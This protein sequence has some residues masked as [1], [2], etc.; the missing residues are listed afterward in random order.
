MGSEIWLVGIEG[1]T[2]TGIK[3]NTC[4][5]LRANTSLIKT[6]N[7]GMDSGVQVKAELFGKT[8]MER[9][10]WFKYRTEKDG[11]CLQPSGNVA[12]LLQMP[13]DTVLTPL[14]GSYSLSSL[15]LKPQIWL[16]IIQWSLFGQVVVQ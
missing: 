12:G 13:R 7:T 6:G 15:Y 10:L 9:G 11:E 3:K 16:I 1:E 2:K 4:F 5:S 14:V 8:N